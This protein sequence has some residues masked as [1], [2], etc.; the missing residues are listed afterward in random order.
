MFKF[1]LAFLVGLVCGMALLLQVQD[2]AADVEQQCIVT[3]KKAGS[4]AN[5]AC[6]N[7]TRLVEWVLWI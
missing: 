2:V 1:S 3:A 6:K 7:E 5:K 4:D